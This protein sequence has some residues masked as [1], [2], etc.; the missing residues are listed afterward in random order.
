[1][2]DGL[3]ISERGPEIRARKEQLGESLSFRPLLDLDKHGM[4][5][6]LQSHISECDARPQN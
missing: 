2:F 5:L 1:M 3:K 6:I 4:R